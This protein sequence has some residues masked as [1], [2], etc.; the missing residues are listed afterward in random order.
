M[1]LGPVTPSTIKFNI[2]THNIHQLPKNEIKHIKH[3]M[4]IEII[5]EQ[6]FPIITFP[7][8]AFQ[9]IIALS[10][11][12]PGQPFHQKA[13]IAINTYLHGCPNNIAKINFI[14][15]SGTHL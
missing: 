11:R 14:A 3:S 12:F 6:S 2:A 1:T 5:G 13:G 10:T 15:R 4:Y 7:F 8:A 9:S